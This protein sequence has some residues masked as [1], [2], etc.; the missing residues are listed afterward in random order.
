MD[1]LFDHT[2]MRRRRLRALA[3]FMPGA[4]FLLRRVAEDMADRLSV[5]ERR[6]ETP[7]QVHG[8]LT[9]P[10]ELM[11]ATG[12]TA[13]FS[14]VDQHP[15][16]GV[17]AGNMTLADPDRVPIVPG[18]A[19]LIISPLALHLT[20]DTPG[21]LVQ[22][23]RALKPDGLLLAATPGAGTLGELRESLLAAESELTGGANTRVHPFADIRDYGALLQRAGFALPVTDIDDIVVRY[24]DMFGL[25]KDLRA[26]GMTSMLLDRS[27]K[28]VG[29]S[30]FL[31]AAQIYAERFSDPDGRI[32]ASFPVIHLSGWAPHESQQ[33]PLKPGSAKTRLADALRTPEQKLPR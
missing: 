21:V 2:L 14:F 3:G 33:K 24:A 16:P 29:R 22:M 5:V 27:R 15:L 28:P 11:S 8:G 31:R 12:K 26:M 20:N 18:S 23:R 10:A 6:F 13:E 32:R 30:V 17:D 25:L 19:D 9:L 1:A 7:F 4:D